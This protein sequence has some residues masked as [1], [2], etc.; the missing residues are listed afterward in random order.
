MSR[1][2]IGIADAIARL[3]EDD[4]KNI[5]RYL[6][7]MECDYRFTLTEKVQMK[8]AGKK[9]KTGLDKLLGALKE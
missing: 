4:I 1:K 7:I 9:I 3:K 2:L 8:K 5:N 6:E